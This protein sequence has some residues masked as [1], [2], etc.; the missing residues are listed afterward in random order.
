ML[1]PL[2]TSTQHGLAFPVFGST[3][4]DRKRKVPSTW[5]SSNSPGAL[6]LA[7]KQLALIVLWAT[8]LVPG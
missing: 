4:S 5:D 8:R 2:S 3:A 6:S 1:L 7:S